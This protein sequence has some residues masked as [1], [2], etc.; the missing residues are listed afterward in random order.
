MTISLYRNND[1]TPLARL[2]SAIEN[3]RLMRQATYQRQHP[4]HKRFTQRELNDTACPTYK[5]YL[6]GRSQRLP[7][8]ESILAIAAY[9][10]C[11]PAERDHLLRTAGYLP[12]PV[13]PA[14]AVLLPLLAHGR[15][16]MRDLQFPALLITRDYQ[17]HAVCPNMTAL[18]GIPPIDMLPAGQRSL[19]DLLSQPPLSPQLTESAREQLSAALVHHLKYRS[20]HYEQQ[21]WYLERVRAIYSAGDLRLLWRSI[22]PNDLPSTLTGTALFNGQPVRFNVMLSPVDG[23]RTLTILWLLP[24]DAFARATFEALGCQ[25]TPHAAEICL[26]WERE[27]AGMTG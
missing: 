6:D 11:T 21:A 8:R 16:L 18:V 2:V 13:Q 12:E 26:R 5:N 23:E 10:E 14:S 22:Q 17:V 19:F 27:Y 20:Q 7:E 24:T 4:A 15:K 25:H 1:D 3:L 9:L